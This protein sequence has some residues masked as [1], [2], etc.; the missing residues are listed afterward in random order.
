ME[1]ERRAMNES[2]MDGDI[3]DADCIDTERRHQ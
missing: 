2:S 3:E 1:T